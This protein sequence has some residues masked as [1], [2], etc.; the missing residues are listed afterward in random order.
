[1]LYNIID[2]E[3]LIDDMDQDIDTMWQ[4]VDADSDG[5]EASVEID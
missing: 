3:D 4:L 2:A 5:G 1:M